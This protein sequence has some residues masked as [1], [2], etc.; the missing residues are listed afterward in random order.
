MNDL[1][2]A[3]V[4]EYLVD[5]NAEGAARRAGYSPK[6]ARANSYKLLADPTISAAIAATQ[7]ERARRT[8]I[9]ADAVLRRWWDI[10][11]ADA[12]DLVQF[13]RRCCRHCW[14]QDHAYQWT[15]PEY[16]A[17]QRRAAAGK[18]P[19]PDAVGGLDYDR[20][21]EPNP[22]CPECRGE[23]VGAVHIADTTRVPGP[24]RLLY[25]GVKEGKDGLEVKLQ[26]QAKALEMVARHLGMFAGKG[27]NP[28]TVSVEVNDA[29][30]RIAGRLARLAAAEPKG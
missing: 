28:V 20:T 2:R 6:N 19:E 23:G 22:G 24:G 14:G 3:F 7:A 12:N 1:Q 30:D 8:E 18:G 15:R 29:R 26:D 13:R 9:T 11:T 5:L 27:E 21:R 16:E 17:A 25:A 4:R 10:A